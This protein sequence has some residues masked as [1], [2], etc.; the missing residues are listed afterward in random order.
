M[1]GQHLAHVPGAPLPTLE[2]LL[3]HV[4]KFGLDISHKETPRYKPRHT[5]WNT[6]ASESS[7]EVAIE[8]LGIEAFSLFI[9]G[10]GYPHYR[11]QARTA[12]RAIRNL[13]KETPTDGA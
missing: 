10:I 11:E 12:W 1:P 7:V 3:E 8:A 6:L 2:G 9:E 4:R 13:P 5:A